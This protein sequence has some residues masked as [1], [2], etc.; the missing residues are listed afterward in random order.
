MPEETFSTFHSYFTYKEF[1]LR[2]R[3]N[4]PPSL[5]QSLFCRKSP[6]TFHKMLI[7]A[8]SCITIFVYGLLERSV[9]WPSLYSTV[10]KY[11]Q[12]QNAVR[13]G[14]LQ[15]A[16]KECSVSLFIS[17]VFWENLLKLNLVLRSELFL[18]PS[19]QVICDH[20]KVMPFRSLS[21]IFKEKDTRGRVG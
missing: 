7:S 2:I 9:S 13:L 12:D 11:G 4:L 16:S 19:S 17:R 8:H 21:W 5:P 15:C 10:G 14:C 3:L 20:L 6:L 1:T 18:S